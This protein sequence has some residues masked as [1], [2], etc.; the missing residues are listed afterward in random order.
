MKLQR[1]SSEQLIEVAFKVREIHGLVHEWVPK[2]VIDDTFIKQ[3]VDSFTIA[4][5]QEITVLPRTFLREFLFVLD[6]AKEGNDVHSL[7]NI[8]PHTVKRIKHNIEV[9]GGRETAVDV[10]L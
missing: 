3:Y 10:E 4:F 1:F 7:L 9:A 2:N 5:D 6:A 8:S